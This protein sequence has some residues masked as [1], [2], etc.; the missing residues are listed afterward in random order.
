[1]FDEDGA[2]VRNTSR[3][4]DAATLILVR[5][6]AKA[7][8]ILMGRRHD[9]MAFHP[10]KYV[11]PGGRMDPCDQRI[12]AGGE[13]KRAVME[14]L[15]R[16]ISPSRARGLALAAVRETFEETGVLVGTRAQK[17]PHTRAAGWARFFAHGVVPELQHLEYIGRAITPPNRPRRF[18]ARFFMADADAVALTL[19][20]TG[21]DEL[22]EACWVTFAEARALDLPTITRRMV[23]EAEAR[24]GSS[25]AVHPVP[26]FYFRHGKAFMD[27]L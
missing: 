27:L 6:D 11:F 2:I 17:A 25:G 19:D 7:P 8:R 21:T 15:A 3:P 10:G 5:R 16:D 20:H 13:L 18:D 12:A 4:K 26:F 9:S 22:L 24:I 23:A 14:K 1:M